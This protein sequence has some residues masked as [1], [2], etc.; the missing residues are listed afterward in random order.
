MIENM[1]PELSPA[2]SVILVVHGYSERLRWTLERLRSQTL[3]SEL[4]CIIVARSR[5]GLEDLG[6]A[7]HGLRC[8]Q[9]VEH[10]GED[11]E[12]ALKA[13]GV[14]AAR[15]PLVVFIEDHSFPEPDWAEALVKAHE[16]GEYAAV[17]PVVLNANPTSGPSWGCFLVYYGQYMWVPQPQEVRHLPGNHSCYRRDVLCEYGPRLP[18]MLQAEIVLH[19]D[20]TARGKLLRQEPAA[21]VYHLNYSRI[22]PSAHEYYLASRVFA[23]ERSQQWT[24]GKRAV[25][26]AGSP[27]LPIIRLRR[28]LADARRAGLDRRVVRSALPAALL[29]LCAGAA[30]EMAGY[31]LGPSDAR[32]SLMKFERE[33]DSGFTPR[34]L[35]TLA[36]AVEPRH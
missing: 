12:G 2:M 17:G 3:A 32:E 5:T 20:L 21:K 34:E 36:S 35:E 11:S 10:Q 13:A 27:L 25:Y 1:A 28:I 30:G 22:G 4:E 15:A 26:T 24:L 6:T 9:L 19:Q 16:Q 8:V 31:G 23:A 29:T 33:R 7:T 14:R 18:E